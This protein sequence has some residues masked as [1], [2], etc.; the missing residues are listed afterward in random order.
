MVPLQSQATTPKATLSSQLHFFAVHEAEQTPGYLFQVFDPTNRPKHASNS[1]NLTSEPGSPPLFRPPKQPCQKKPNIRQTRSPALYS[2]RRRDHN[3]G[4]G[5]VGAARPG[6]GQE[7]LVGP[8]CE[9]AMVQEK[10]T[11]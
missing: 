1:V 4:T 10:D 2:A 9:S 7:R 11:T 5:A 3:W 6:Q 8:T